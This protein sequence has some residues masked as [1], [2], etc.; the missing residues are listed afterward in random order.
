MKKLYS[1]IRPD[2]TKFIILVVLII[3]SLTITTDFYPTS[4]VSWTA[5][6]GFPLPFLVIYEYVQ[7]KRCLIN[8][9]C[10]SS[11]IQEFYP[12]LIVID[13]LV[14]YLVSCCLITGYE[15]LQYRLKVKHKTHKH[16]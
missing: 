8:S 14:W 4:K 16:S 12:Y 15:I 7:G 2:C 3:L 6:K 1:F 11:N 10:F 13:I 5:K 9:I